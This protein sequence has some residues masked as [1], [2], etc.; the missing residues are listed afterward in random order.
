MGPPLNRPSATIS[1][2][3]ERRARNA[4]R[5]SPRDAGRWW[6]GAPGE[7]RRGRRRAPFPLRLGP[8]AIVR[9]A[10]ADGGDALMDRHF[11]LLDRP[12]GVIEIRDGDAR[13]AL[14]DGALD[15]AEVRLLVRRDE[16]DGVAG[17]L[18]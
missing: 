15:G 10:R 7:G 9:L 3:A 17:H 14:A 4:D 5:S 6:R 8:R 11:Q 13:K 2:R 18:R 16:R 12:V 1:P